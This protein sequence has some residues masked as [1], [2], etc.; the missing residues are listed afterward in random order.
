MRRRRAGAA[1][2]DEVRADEALA[3]AEA[4]AAAETFAAA[5]SAAAAEALAESPLDESNF[6]LDAPIRTSFADPMAAATAEDLASLSAAAHAARPIPRPLVPEPG[7]A[8]GASGSTDGT[9]GTPRVRGRRVN[10]VLTRIGLFVLT[11]VLFAGGVALGVT[12]FERT[13]PAPQLVGDLSTG[14]IVAPP[15]VKELTDALTKNDS[16][17]LRSAVSGDPYRL[18]A[19]EMQSWN[20]QGVTSVETLATMQDGPRTAT[21]IVISGRSADAG[22]RRVQPRGPREGQPDR[23]LPMTRIRNFTMSLGFVWNKNLWRFLALLAILS[24]LIVL[25]GT[26]AVVSSVFAF[27]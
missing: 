23:E 8:D 7:E 11:L 2:R 16:D 5:G 4:K 20:M 19:G 25:N 15:V 18:L 27:L 22:A 24:I 12:A 26:V 9:K 14:G 17:S 21:E 6:T 3:A 13:R 10:L 1:T